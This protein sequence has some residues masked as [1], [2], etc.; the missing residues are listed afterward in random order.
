MSGD[1]LA[2]LCRRLGVDDHYIDIW[3][4]R[5]PVSTAAQR[6]ALAAMGVL[7]DPEADAEVA[8]ARLV[9][10]EWREILPPVQVTGAGQC[11]ELPL[12]LPAGIEAL[13][14]RLWLFL[15]NG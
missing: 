6:S 10:D 11:A 1:A 13:D 2:E 12:H 4:A 14:W 3:G 9:R 5:R 15:L 7:P 8:L